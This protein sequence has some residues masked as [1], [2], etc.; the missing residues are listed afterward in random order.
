MEYRRVL[1]TRKFTAEMKS[2]LRIMSY[3]KRRSAK[4]NV[5]FVTFAS[6]VDMKLAERAAKR[7]RNVTLKPYQHHTDQSNCERRVTNQNN[8]SW[9]QSR[10]YFT[11]AMTV[12]CVDDSIS[13]NI[14]ARQNSSYPLLE[15]LAEKAL[16]VF[17]PLEPLLHDVTPVNSFVTDKEKIFQLLF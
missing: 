15:T 13:T 16:R 17:G 11:S 6:E 3:D 12:G 5:Y 7:L 8:D 10:E 4:G 14:A 9:S 1:Y 2:K